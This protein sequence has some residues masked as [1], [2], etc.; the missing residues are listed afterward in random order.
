MV[1]KTQDFLEMYCCCCCK[2]FIT[3]T[4][5][6]QCFRCAVGFVPSF[7]WD[8]ARMRR[9]H[10][11]QAY[12]SFRGRLTHSTSRDLSNL[13]RHC[14]SSRSESRPYNEAKCFDKKNHRLL[15]EERTDEMTPV[16]THTKGYETLS[17]WPVIDVQVF[18][19]RLRRGNAKILFV[20]GEAVDNIK[21]PSRV[22][23]CFKLSTD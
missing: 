20:A 15:S 2:E 8:A 1:C 6:L 13:T 12:A 18:Y 22:L 16:M 14:R 17:W 10:Y 23:F 19:A 5:W 21:K 9:S 7:S 11:T 4:D 3:V